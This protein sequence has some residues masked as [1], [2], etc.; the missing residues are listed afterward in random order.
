M[1]TPIDFAV[2]ELRSAAEE[3]YRA[4]KDNGLDVVLDD[5]NLRAGVKFKD[6]DLVGIPWRVT[7]GK[8]LAQGL[9]EVV[10][11]SPKR[12][13]DIPVGEAAAFVA[14]NIRR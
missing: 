9:V 10:A 14:S 12:S 4:A 11:R 3:I 5:R 2:D 7:I 6:A 1:I 8:K 13:T